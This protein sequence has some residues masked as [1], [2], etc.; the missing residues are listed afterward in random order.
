MMFSEYHD[1]ATTANNVFLLKKQ[2]LNFVIHKTPTFHLLQ[3]AANE[4]AIHF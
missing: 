4:V 2:Q 3:N 1:V